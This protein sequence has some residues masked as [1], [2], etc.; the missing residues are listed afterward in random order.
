MPEQKVIIEN[1]PVLLEDTKAV[2]GEP[3]APTPKWVKVVISVTTRVTAALAIYMVA[4]NLIKED[5]KFEIM[6]GLK[7]TDFLVVELGKM[8][9]LVEKN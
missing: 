1:K 9:G 4:T 3:S 8:V 2:F 7:A 5:V 6:L